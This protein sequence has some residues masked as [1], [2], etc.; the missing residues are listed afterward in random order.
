M[1]FGESICFWRGHECVC[2]KALEILIDLNQRFTEQF[3]LDHF[4]CTFF[5]TSLILFS[6]WKYRMQINMFLMRPWSRVLEAIEILIDLQLWFP[7]KKS[8]KNNSYFSI[9]SWCFSCTSLWYTIWRGHEWL[10]WKT[11]EILI[12][13]KQSFTEKFFLDH[14]Y[15]RLSDTSLC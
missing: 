15:A 9:L 10:R 4:I 8:T 12:D 3:L 6:V 11:L 7:E 5:C 13:S 2:W 1:Y 14:F